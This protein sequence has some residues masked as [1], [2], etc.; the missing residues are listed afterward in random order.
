MVISCP[1]ETRPRQEHEEETKERGLMLI[2]D[3]L[4]SFDTPHKEELAALEQESKVLER[5]N[6]DL[7]YQLKYARVSAKETLVEVCFYQNL[8]AF[9]H[10][11]PDSNQASSRSEG[12]YSQT[13]YYCS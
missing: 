3:L 6:L 12:L 13:E 4:Q 5:E 1:Q 10:I 11:T 9:E 7:L 8:H 2:L